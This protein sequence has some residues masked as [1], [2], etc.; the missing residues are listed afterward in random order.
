MSDAP[1]KIFC[2]VFYAAALVSLFVPMP[3]W[4]A[5]TLQFGT[6]ALFVAHAIEVALCLRWIRMYPGSLAVSIVLT[7]LF[8]FVHW[9][10]FKRQFEAGGVS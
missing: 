5:A 9:M 4:L 1:A 2:L 7:L 8:G 3:G 6:V 10:P